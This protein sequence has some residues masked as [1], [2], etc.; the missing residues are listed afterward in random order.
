[1]KPRIFVHI[2]GMEIGGAERALLGLLSA[3]DPNRVSVDLFINKHHGEFFDLIPQ[4]VNILPE[5]KPYRALEC[6][7][8][9]ALKE[10]QWNIAFRRLLGKYRHLN[11]VKNHIPDVDD[12]YN[13]LFQYIADSVDAG[14][15]SLEYLGEYDLA[16]SFLTPHNIVLHKVKS[17]KK[18]CWIHTDYGTIHLDVERERRIWGKYD[19]IISIGEECTRGFLRKFPELKSKIVE[20]ENILSTTFIL[21]QASLQDVSRE[22]PLLDGGVN[23]LTVGRFS[24]PKKMDGIPHIAAEML[25]YDIKFRWYIIG[26][27]DD[28]LIQDALD[29]YNMRDYVVIL[30]KKTNPYPYIAACDIYAQPSLFEGKSVAVREA[31]ILHKPVVVTNYPT[32]RSQIREGIDGVIVPMEEAETAKKMV[33]FISDIQKQKQIIRYLTQND[34]GNETAVELLYDLI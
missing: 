5:S 33:E 7:L 17:K 9:Q 15:P 18:I 12:K 8:K 20:I 10:G 2:R 32:A 28:E 22:I 24:P 23:I 25:K 16:I 14:L 13:S 26:Y 34:Y 11:F 27:G 29:K 3:I 1:M 31:Q 21:N 6:S 30:G 4:Y 19:H